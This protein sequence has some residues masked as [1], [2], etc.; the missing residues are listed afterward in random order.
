MPR[1]KKSKWQKRKEK[2]IEGFY[3]SLI[4]ML[5]DWIIFLI[6]MKILEVI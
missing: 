2:I 4:P 1:R 3:W 5:I 6:I